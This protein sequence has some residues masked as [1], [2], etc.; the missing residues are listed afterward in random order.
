MPGLG[1]NELLSMSQQFSGL[2]MDSLIGGP[3]NAA[4]SANGTMAANQVKFML[5]TC[6]TKI[7]VQAIGKVDAVPG[8]AGTPAVPATFDATSGAQLTPGTPAVPGKMPI[9]EVPASSEYTNYQPIMINMSLTR[10]VIT[11]VS[12]TASKVYQE[13]MQQYYEIVKT[14][15]T[16][17]ANFPVVPKADIQIITTAFNLPLLTIIPLNSLA[18]QTVNI[19]FEMEVKSSYGEDH[20][21]ESSKSMAAEASFEAKINYGI[22]SASVKGS[23]STKSEDKTSESS[24]Y[25]KSNTAKYTVAVTAGQIPL[26]EGV[27]TIIDAF[28][29]AI[30]PVTMPVPA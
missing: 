7:V 25:E 26:P 15:G 4:A 16:I 6:F 13:S 23:A 5:D 22:S 24:H 28:A 1:Q 14:G 10:Q 3:L 29:G 12:T 8:T 21:N 27:K 11:P 2:P 20:S 18:V 9:P 17:P 30:V 19:N